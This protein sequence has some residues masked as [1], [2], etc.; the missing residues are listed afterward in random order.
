MNGVS[1]CER[2]VSSR[3]CY[4]H[5]EDGVDEALFRFLELVCLMSE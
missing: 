3:Q 5:V 1:L 4:I 2:K